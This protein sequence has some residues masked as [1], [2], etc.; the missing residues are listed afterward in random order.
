MS[1]SDNKYKSIYDELINDLA[2]KEYDLNIKQGEIQKLENDLKIILADIH[3]IRVAAESIQ[4]LFPKE[5]ETN[6]EPNHNPLLEQIAPTISKKQ[7]IKWRQEILKIFRENP[8][9]K[10]STS[11]LY[12]KIQID[13]PDNKDDRR[14]QVTNI[15]LVLMSL[16]RSG[17]IK[18]EEFKGRGFQYS[19]SDS[20]NEYPTL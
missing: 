14:K 19:L 4:K 16:V 2:M 10:F 9:T 8:E 13:K 1:Q 6:Q 20:Y 15:S 17:R 5:I 3:R 18:K 11:E 12:D 7:P